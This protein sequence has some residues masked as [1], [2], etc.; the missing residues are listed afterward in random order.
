[1]FV[2]LKDSPSRT[3]TALPLLSAFLSSVG[4]LIARDVNSFLFSRKEINN[5]NF[6]TMICR[7]TFGE[8]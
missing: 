4:R 5:H 7:L 3:H 2:L 1:M 8:S 6:E